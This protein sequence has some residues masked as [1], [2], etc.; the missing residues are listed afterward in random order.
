MAHSNFPVRFSNLPVS[1]PYQVAE[2]L[3]NA[4]DSGGNGTLEKQEFLK[5]VSQS[6]IRTPRLARSGL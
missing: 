4:Y 5:M 2:T 3:V 1:S 6:G